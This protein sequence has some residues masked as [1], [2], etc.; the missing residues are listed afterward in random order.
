MNKRIQELYLLAFPPSLSD[1]T[2]V[3][4]SA[5]EFAKLIVQECFD[6]VDKVDAILEDDSEKVGVAWVGLA[7]AKHFGVE[8]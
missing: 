5:N 2:L 3:T 1:S 7:M 8:E 6:Q 4:A